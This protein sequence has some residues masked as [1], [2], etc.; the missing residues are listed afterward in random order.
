MAAD[1]YSQQVSCEGHY[2][3]YMDWYDDVIGWRFYAMIWKEPKEKILSFD[4]HT[5]FLL[6]GFYRPRQPPMPPPP[7][8]HCRP[9][10]KIAVPLRHAISLLGDVSFDAFSMLISSLAASRCACSSIFHL[11]VLQFIFIKMLTLAMEEIF[12]F[13]SRYGDIRW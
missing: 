13:A 8:A 6:I 1:I 11:L 7:N 10:S 3:W 9:L 4:Y 5:K 12:R 2:F